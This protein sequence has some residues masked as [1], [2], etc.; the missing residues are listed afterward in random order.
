MLSQRIVPV[1]L[2]VILVVAGC[3]GQTPL[4]PSADDEPSP[5]SPPTKTTLDEPATDQPAPDQ[6]AENKT[7]GGYDADVL[8]KRIEES[9]SQLSAEDRKLAEAQKYCPVGARFDDEGR[10]VGTLLGSI[11]KPVRLMVEGEPV[12]IACPS[13]TQPFKDD[14]AIY[15][16]VL[17]KIRASRQKEN[18]TELQNL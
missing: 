9:M 17:A 11:G 3:G 14:T 15:M 5:K 10:P 16:R 12:F 1:C 4:G 18:A 6:G 7:V 8:S 2:L 13:C